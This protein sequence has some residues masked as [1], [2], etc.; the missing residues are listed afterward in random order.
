MRIEKKSEIRNHI[1]KL[2]KL[3]VKRRDTKQKKKREFRKVRKINKII[4]IIFIITI[5]STI[6]YIQLGKNKEKY[7]R[8]QANRV[9]KRI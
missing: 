9:E 5:N 6:K 3:L 8:Y 2:E 1:D 4:F 7:Y